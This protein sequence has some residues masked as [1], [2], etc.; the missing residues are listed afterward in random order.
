MLHLA[1]TSTPECQGERICGVV[2]GWRRLQSEELCN[3]LR[4]RR[5]GRAALT[6]NRALHFGRR[7][8]NHFNL[9][10]GGNQQGNATHGTNR[11]GGLHV[12]LRKDA[13]NRDPVG[14]LE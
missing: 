6:S 14:A 9:V 4:H 2:W 7:G 8:F 1:R 10:I 12:G 3:G 13:L 11:H 5:L